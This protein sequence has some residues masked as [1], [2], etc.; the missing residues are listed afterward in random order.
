M[1]TSVLLLASLF[2]LN[3]VNAQAILNEVYTDPGHGKHEF[4]ELYNTS[5]SPLPENLDNYTIVTYYE[6]TGKTGFY[7]LDMPNM[8]VNAK[9]YFTGSSANPFNVQGQSGVTA[10]FSW[11]NMPAG[12][13]LTK[14]ERNGSSYTQVTVPANINDIFVRRTGSGAAHHIFIFNNGVLINGLIG[15]NSSSLIPTY[16]KNMPTLFVDMTGSSPD[17]T[18]NFNAIANNQVEYVTPSTGT[19]NGYIRLR[20]GKCG[21]WDKSTSQVNHTPGISNGSA[22]GQSGQLT[23]TAYISYGSNPS[24]PSILNYGITSGPVDA[25]PVIIEV[26]RD[27]GVSGQLDASDV[28]I[29]TIQVNGASA[30]LNQVTLP[31]KN[32]QAILVCKSVAGCYDIVVPVVNN[33]STLPVK[34]VS[35]NG[36]LNN[37]KVTLQWV[38]AENEIADKFEIEKSL[39]GTNF[40]TA[41]VVFGSDKTGT[42]NYQFAETMNSDKVFY[43]LRMTDK[44]Q[45]VNYS[46][47][48]MF[49]NAAIVTDNTNSIRI[50][51]NPATDRLSFSFQLVAAQK[52]EVKVYDMNGRMMLKQQMNGSQG[53]NQASIQL[54]AAMQSGIYIIEVNTGTERLTAKFVKK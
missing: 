32:D 52:A 31:N 34:L 44:S 30:S 19:D 21:V 14:W 29:Q 15:G 33:R 2:A 50:L 26:Y 54:A 17:F 24:D 9:S 27:L 40:S 23:A 41:A 28:M 25:F 7:V 22:A 1:K 39:D 11:N 3:A 47:T 12:G 51:N 8:T 18:I 53:N 42:E 45:I 5:T 37:K 38:V 10:N 4:F 35:F 43:R 13:A 46:K 20:D 36:N 16:L 48:L 49:Q 6:E